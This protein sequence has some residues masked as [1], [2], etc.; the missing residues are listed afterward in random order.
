MCVR[1]LLSMCVRMRV[2]MNLHGCWFVRVSMYV[3][4]ETCV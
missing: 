4:G 2:H 1:W 3:P